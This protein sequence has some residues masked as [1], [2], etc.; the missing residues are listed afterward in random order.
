M[1]SEYDKLNDA[2]SRIIDRPETINDF[3]D[4]A[5]LQ[6]LL[7][8]AQIGLRLP[9]NRVPRPTKRYKFQLVQKS[10]LFSAKLFLQLAS[11][12]LAT[13]VFVSIAAWSSVPGEGLFIVKK[14]M[15]QTR[16]EL[17]RN[18]EERALAQVSLV[19]KRMNEVQTVLSSDNNN[20]QAKVAALNELASQTKNASESVKD[21]ALIDN[22]N[23][24]TD[25]SLIESLGQIAQKQEALLATISTGD[26]KAVDTQVMEP[27]SKTKT[28]VAEVKKIL[29][30][31]N[32]QT[33]ASLPTPEPLVITGIATKVTDTV[34]TIDKRIITITPETKIFLKDEKTP[35]DSKN[36]DKKK[37]RVTIQEADTLVAEKIIILDTPTVK[38]ET[39]KPVIK[40][41]TPK[42]EEIKPEDL[43]DP[44]III[45]EQNRVQTG[46]ILEDPNP[47]YN[48]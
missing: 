2:I 21:V 46:Y 4:N 48:P 24:S 9:T 5:E 44:T 35:A 11:G 42:P 12:G 41:T 1:N 22:G 3:A 34:I 7:Q 6:E 37:V 13:L 39:T 8:T 18:P 23:P 25:N 26:G 15:E 10:R 33:M 43:V 14:A 20:E 19:Q 40:P 17:I 29:A 31:V 27:I 16:L 45:E 38:G 28:A 47:T 36:L 32:E 30:T